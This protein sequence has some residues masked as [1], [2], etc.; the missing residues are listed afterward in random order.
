MLQIESTFLD[1]GHLDRLALMD[2]P[3]HRLDA[4]AKLITTLLFIALVVSFGKYELAALLPFFIFPVSLAASAGIP[5]RF[6]FKRLLLVAPFA[7][8]VGIFNPLLDDSMIT[9]GP[10][11]I[12]AGWLSFA[13]ILLRFMLCVSAAFILI[14]TTG[15]HQLCRGLEKLHV[16]QAFVVQLLLLYRYLFLLVEEAIRL[17]RARSLR[18]T[19]RK[20][21]G[22]KDT[23]ALLGQLLWRTLSRARRIYLAMEC[24]GFKGQFHLLK[25][26][27]IQP[28]DMAFTL[29]WATAFLLMRFI[30]LPQYLGNIIN[31]IIS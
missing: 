19:G 18:S 14:A 4:R 30:N 9:L 5:L 25:T 24:R 21:T 12:S 2:S 8:L 22:I 29:A 15:F 17:L 6:L 10:L 13:S 3:V 1:I 27:R 16:P 7:V 11:R 31:G 23:G 20:G 28:A 26:R